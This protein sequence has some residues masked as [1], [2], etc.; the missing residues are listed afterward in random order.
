[1]NSRCNNLTEKST[2]KPVESDLTTVFLVSQFNF[3]KRFDLKFLNSPIPF[4][5]KTKSRELARTFLG[6]KTTQY[7][8][9]QSTLGN[10]SHMISN[11]F[12]APWEISSANIKSEVE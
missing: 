1:M 12:P 7:V 10:P 3:P 4:D 5:N 2:S 11:C 9:E 8:I 6:F